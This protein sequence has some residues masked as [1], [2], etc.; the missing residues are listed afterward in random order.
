MEETDEIKT[1]K[2]TATTQPGKKSHTVLIITVII[3]LLA[4]AGGAYFFYFEQQ[5]VNDEA[6][7]YEILEG[8]E[9]LD[10]YQ[11][12]LDHFPNGEHAEEVKERY[13]ALQK[14]YSE[15]DGLAKRATRYDYER[16]KKNYPNSILVHQCDL[17]IDSLDW[18]T[19]T[20][21]GTAEAIAA[22][23][24]EHP[25]GRYLSE[26]SITQEQINEAQPTDEERIAI[27]LALTKFFHA[28]GNNDEEN[29]NACITPVMTRFLSKAN[30]TK[31][32]VAGIIDRTYNEHIK[33]CK[34]V[35]NNDYSI[36]KSQTESGE[37]QYSV[38]FSVDQYIERDN[39]GKTFGS[40]TAEATLT[41]NF[42]ISALTM[43]E[44]SR[45]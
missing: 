39:E 29:I 1:G 37:K 14:M 38:A 16:F 20:E 27:E 43:N 15:W 12:Y 8:N 35:L 26:A 40:Y 7:A 22:Y 34:F 10:D 11:A 25:D 18:V 28:F 9:S 32:D 36:K 42:M 45:R 21:A 2:E 24:A 13:A 6:T 19:A 5:K 33:N 4:A 41:E 3:L 23:I 44:A 30:A 31:V 17:K